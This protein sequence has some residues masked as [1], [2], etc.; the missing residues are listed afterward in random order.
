[1]AI[2]KRYTGGYEVASPV[3]SFHGMSDAARAVTFS[4]WRQGY[5]P[6]APGNY[7]I[8]APYRYRC[9][10]C[11][12]RDACDYTCLDTSFELLDAQA[13]GRMAAVITEPLFSAGGV[14]EPPPGWLQELKLRCEWRGHAADPGRGADRTGQAGH[15][16]GLGARRGGA[17]HL[18]HLEA[19]RRRHRHQ[20]RPSPPTR[21]RRMQW[22]PAWWSPTPTPTTR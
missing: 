2:A 10:F 3:V 6:Y 12:D 17:G 4:G 13:D 8:I 14:I 1:M 18:H 7:P 16:V 22:T 21:S 15:D 5:G 20:L 11:K 9:A 19:L